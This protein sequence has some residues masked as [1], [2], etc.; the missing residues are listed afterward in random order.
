LRSVDE[1]QADRVAKRLGDLG[2]ADRLLAL[3]VGV[4]DG[5]AAALPGGSLLLGS[6]LQIDRHRYTYTY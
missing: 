3:D 6:Q 1:L 5:L 4:G 2:H